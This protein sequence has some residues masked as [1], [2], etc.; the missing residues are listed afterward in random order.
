MTNKL[1][2]FVFTAVCS[3]ALPKGRER[4][5]D[6][7]WQF[8]LK[9]TSSQMRI[10]SCQIEAMFIV[11]GFFFLNHSSM[12]LKKPCLCLHSLPSPL[13][14][15]HIAVRQAGQMNCLPSF[16][17]FLYSHL[18]IPTPPKASAC[19]SPPHNSVFDYEKDK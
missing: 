17:L 14:K 19:F 6:S 2:L 11:E 4:E 8:V 13:C 5:K 15:P 16:S 7:C 3:N 10:S 18:H 9:L 1:Q 12:K